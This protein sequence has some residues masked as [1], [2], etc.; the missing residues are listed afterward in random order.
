MNSG[1]PFTYLWNTI[2]PQNTA[3]ISAPVG[4]A[5]KV[6]VTNTKTGCTYD[7]VATIPGYGRIRAYFTIS[8]AGQCL[9][10]NNALVRIINLSEGGTMGSWNFGDGNILPYDAVQNPS[11]KYQ[12]DTDS[13]TIRL[14]IENDGH[15]RDS[16]QVSVCVLDTISLFIPTAFTPNEDG[17]N[18]VFIITS[19]SITE[20][21]IEIYNR[22]GEKIFYAD[23]PRKG[24]DGFYRGK[25]CPTDY[26]VYTIK[27]KGKKTPW[28]YARGYFY[29]IQ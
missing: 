2:P 18:D 1:G 17:K 25:L 6:H 23:D 14:T 24:W 10:S 3:R 12:G 4:N 7:T 5:Y 29:L 11:Y 28:K 9:Y 26:Y 16:F 20:A 22:W 8:P 27:Y 21:T 19:T 13:Y 15:C